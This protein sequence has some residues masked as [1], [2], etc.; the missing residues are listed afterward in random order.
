MLGR[1]LELDRLVDDDL[2]ERNI[3]IV[4]IEKKFELT[5]QVALHLV[6]GILFAIGDEAQNH[7][8]I[9]EIGDPFV[10]GTVLDVGDR[11][12]DRGQVLFQD[13]F[14]AFKRLAVFDPDVAD[15]ERELIRHIDDGFHVGVVD[16]LD[17]AARVDDLGGADP[18][19]LDRAAETVDHND[20]ADVEN[21]FKD[22]E[23]PGDDVGD[24]RLRAEADDQ[25]EDSDTGED[26]RGIKP[27]G[28]QDE[29]EQ[30]DDRRVL[31]QT[32]NDVNDRFAAPEQ[33]RELHEH[34]ADNEARAEQENRIADHTDHDVIFSRLAEEIET[35]PKDAHRI[36]HRVPER[37]EHGVDDEN[38][39]PDAF[40]DQ[41]GRD[42]DFETELFLFVCHRFQTPCL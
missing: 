40:Q 24:E 39:I 27:R 10:E 8:G 9:A 21:L 28:F 16:D 37:H 18:D 35:A 25:A 32:A 42:P 13:R 26:R 4:F 31:D 20:V 34:E 3:D 29:E 30:H 14:D 36:E 7:G 2:R 23:E 15:R 22:D 5:V 19:L 11:L 1:V 41:I 12:A 33:A 38:Q 6:S 17:I